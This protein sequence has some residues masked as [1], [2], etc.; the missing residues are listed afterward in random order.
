[1]LRKGCP[2]CQGDLYLDRSEGPTMLTC[3]QC[4]RSFAHAALNDNQHD[5]RVAAAAGDRAA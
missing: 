2:R 5:T 4:G 3:L 1:M